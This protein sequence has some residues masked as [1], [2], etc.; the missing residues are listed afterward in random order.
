MI[1][2]QLSE[3]ELTSHVPTFSPQDVQIWKL[4][5]KISE[6]MRAEL[7]LTLSLDE[8]E[9]AQRFIQPHDQLGFVAVRGQLRWLLGQHLGIDP[10]PVTFSYGEKGK[11][12]L[13]KGNGADLNLKFNLSHSHGI[14]LIAL[15]T[16][17]ELGVDLEEISTR[18][19]YEGITQ[20][21]LASGEQEALF[22]QPEVQRC[23]TFF[24][25]WTRKEAC[26]KA[27]GGS[28]AQGLE[29][30]DVSMGLEQTTNTI[31][32]PQAGNVSTTLFIH[33]LQPMTGYAGA[34]ATTSSAD[35][36]QRYTLDF[37]ASING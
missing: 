2:G 24:Q 22:N 19:D 33:D 26:I 34:L 5:L 23:A 27:M 4:S 29:Q 15:T 1:Q 6:A 7:W 30:I 14:A 35:N 16:D 37:P 21:F 8:Q 12:R 25:L 32:L 17:Q 28:I 13:A 31:T 36:L 18:I 10:A 11:P 9:R 20:R 3:W